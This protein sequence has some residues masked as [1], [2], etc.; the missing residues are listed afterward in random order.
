[1]NVTDFYKVSLTPSVNAYKYSFFLRGKTIQMTE[2]LHTE[3]PGIILCQETKVDQH[4]SSNELFPKDLVT[5]Q[6]E[7]NTVQEVAF[8]SQP[9]GNSG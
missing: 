7:R 3:C 9:I 5:F 2:L 8:A 4:I 1:M 6:K